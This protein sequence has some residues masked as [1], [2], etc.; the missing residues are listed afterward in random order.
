M[1]AAK[2]NR[3]TAV[4]SVRTAVGDDQRRDCCG[5]R[6]SDMPPRMPPDP[7]SAL[8]RL[9]VKVVKGRRS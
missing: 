7:P 5:A 1:P 8:M 6:F 4:T 2:R 9:G 3:A